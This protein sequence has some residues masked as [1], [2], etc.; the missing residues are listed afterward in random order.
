MRK[1]G[2]DNLHNL[3]PLLLLSNLLCTRQKA[4]FALEKA[5]GRESALKVG[6]IFD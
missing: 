3:L 6:T 2:E 4:N 5:T 1:S